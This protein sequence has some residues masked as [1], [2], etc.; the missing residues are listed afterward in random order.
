MRTADHQ[1]QHRLACDLTLLR[2]YCA[3]PDRAWRA[4]KPSWEEPPVPAPRPLLRRTDVRTAAAGHPHRLQFFLGGMGAKYGE[5]GIVGQPSYKSAKGDPAKLVA[6]LET[7][8]AEC[9]CDSWYDGKVTKNWDPE[10]PVH[11]LKARW[12]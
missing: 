4:R 12:P 1:R 7:R 8:S 9:K 11:G 5:R 2:F 3:N 10:C 6:F